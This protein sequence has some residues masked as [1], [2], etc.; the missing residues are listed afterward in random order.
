MSTTYECLWSLVVCPLQADP[1]FWLALYQ[2][3]ESY[4]PIPGAKV[5]VDQ[6]LRTATISICHTLYEYGPIQC[7]LSQALQFIAC[8]EQ[9]LKFNRMYAEYNERG[10]HDDTRE[11]IYQQY[12]NV[13]YKGTG[14]ENFTQ[15]CMFDDREMTALLTLSE[16]N[17]DTEI[18]QPKNK[19]DLY[20]LLCTVL[21][22]RV[23]CDKFLTK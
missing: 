20:Q 4:K 23:E 7:Y 3:C 18:P 21:E 15:V 2:A 16:F 5:K 1:L 10:L 11:A 9:E 6:E 22:D 13:G 8:E 12:C 14:T 17:E 19:T